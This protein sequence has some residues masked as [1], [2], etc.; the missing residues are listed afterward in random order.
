MKL[1]LNILGMLIVVA[2]LV[3]F[4][5]FVLIDCFSLIGAFSWRELL[6]AITNTIVLYI[7]YYAFYKGV[8]SVID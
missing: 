8:K 4:G 2:I 7:V 5:I 1:F 6:Q 3:A